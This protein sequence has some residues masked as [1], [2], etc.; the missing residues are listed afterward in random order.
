M[1]KLFFALILV[2]MIFTQSLSFASTITNVNTQDETE[3]Q[4][5]A[6]VEETNSEEPLVMEEAPSE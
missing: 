5:G 3:Q 6:I 2:G 4:E 1:R